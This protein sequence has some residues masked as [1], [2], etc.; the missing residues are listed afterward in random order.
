MLCKVFNKGKH[1]SE[2]Q[3]ERKELIVTLFMIHRVIISFST[4]H[5]GFHKKKVQ[6]TFGCYSDSGT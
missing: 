4:S 1:P 6:Q 5:L 3:I 2:T